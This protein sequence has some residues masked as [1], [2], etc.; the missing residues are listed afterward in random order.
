M[1]SPWATWQCCGRFGRRVT[2]NLSRV[3]RTTYR[4]DEIDLLAVYCGEL[5]QCYLL[6]VALIAGKF[7]IHLRLEPSLNAQR[8]C[9]TLAP[10][11]SS[12]GL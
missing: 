3:R 11:T 7:G 1:G 5:E 4:E 6:P 10:I 2:L 8:A 9:I 12:M